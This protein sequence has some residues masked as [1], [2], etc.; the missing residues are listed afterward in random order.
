V[1]S[2]YKLAGLY[3]EQKKYAEAEPLLKQVLAIQE[4]E[5]GQA[6]LETAD[7]LDALAGL[8][9]EQRNYAAAEPLYER[10]LAI[11]RSKYNPNA[12]NIVE[13]LKELRSKMGK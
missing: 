7:A 8:Y 9:E 5:K 2:L 11:Y 4:K 3:W 12:E 6:A 1:Y 10:A 13:N